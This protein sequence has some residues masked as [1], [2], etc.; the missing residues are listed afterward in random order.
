M[1]LMFS[2]GLSEEVVTHVNSAHED[3]FAGVSFVFTAGTPMQVYIHF[4]LIFTD[5]ND[6]L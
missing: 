2:R 6:E 1:N 5:L 4:L 3:L